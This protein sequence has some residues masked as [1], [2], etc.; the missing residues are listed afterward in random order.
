MVRCT[1]EVYDCERG[2]N[3]VQYALKENGKGYRGCLKART[4]A[5]RSVEMKQS[6]NEGQKP[7]LRGL[8][9]RQEN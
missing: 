7:S 1:G 6:L 5:G 8:C 4:D 3:R 9:E 2:P